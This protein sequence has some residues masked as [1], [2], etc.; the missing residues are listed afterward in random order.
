MEHSA[1]RQSSGAQIDQL[2]I[3]HYRELFFL[4]DGRRVSTLQR[5]TFSDKHLLELP[6][7]LQKRNS[8]DLAD[9]TEFK[10]I[11]PTCPGFV[12]TDECLRFAQRTGQI[13][14]TEA[15]VQPELAKYRQQGLLL[16]SVRREPRPAFVHQLAA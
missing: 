5:W 14:L 8:E 4:T 11:E 1:A 3:P 9:L 7:E 13:N 15:S 12:V 6:D 16:L 2:V 10:Q